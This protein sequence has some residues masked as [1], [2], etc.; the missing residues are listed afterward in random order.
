MIITDN[1]KIARKA[2]LIIN[3]G[4]A[5]MERHHDIDELANII[6]FN[7][8][9]PELSAALGRAQIKKLDLVNRK[10]NENFKFL[11]EHL[12]GIDGFTAPFISQEVSYVCH[13]AG[14]LYDSKKTGL[15][16]DL[17]L[18]A[19]RA[20]GV[21]V[22]SGYVRLMYQNPLFLRQVAY[23]KEGC[24]WLCGKE[25][26]S[27]TYSNGQCPVAEELIDEKFLWFY[28]IGHP[29]TLEDMGDVIS[30]IKKV[31]KGRDS[32]IR[33]A[34]EILGTGAGNKAQGRIL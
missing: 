13:V 11:V 3:H 2:R 4:E 34:D 25:Q 8:R 6:G 28:H 1:P 18:A 23:G 7:F 10:R 33:H 26:S 21:P 15:L 30:A 32:L 12:G 20:E 31:L 24:P 19:V 29:S 14:F 22:G 9:M 27:V 17:F 5:V 16:R